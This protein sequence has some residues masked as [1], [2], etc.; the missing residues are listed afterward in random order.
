MSEASEDNTSH[1]SITSPQRGA[2]SSN[3]TENAWK[4]RQSSD[5]FAG[6][7]R[8]S[9]APASSVYGS[10]QAP[11][12]G[13]GKR[14][15]AHHGR[16]GGDRG[17]SNKDRRGGHGGDSRGGSRGGRGGG[18]QERPAADK[19]YKNYNDTKAYNEEPHDIGFVNK[20]AGLQVDVDEVE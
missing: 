12:S 10:Q 14:P 3:P 20:F 2:G 19:V 8:G 5:L 11:R 7:E 13:Y 6:Q 17:Y 15:E 4:S 18:Y 9:Q 16:G 1:N